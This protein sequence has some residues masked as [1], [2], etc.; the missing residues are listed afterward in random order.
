MNKL[1]RQENFK[2]L[3]KCDLLDHF[4]K[5][6]FLVFQTECFRKFEE[7]NQLVIELKNLLR[8]LLQSTERNN[9]TVHQYPALPLRTLEELRITETIV[10]SNE[11][12]YKA[13]VIIL[14]SAFSLIIMFNLFLNRLL[15]YNV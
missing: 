4:F 2:V 12:Q 15:K 9:G 8:T 13:L 3:S 5:F 11:E 6:I 14:N 7:G 1:L 10:S